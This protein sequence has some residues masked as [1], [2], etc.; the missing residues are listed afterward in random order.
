MDL[1]LLAVSPN[2]GSLPLWEAGE[3]ALQPSLGSL[4]LG[5]TSLA[6]SSLAQTR[7]ELLAA[8]TQHSSTPCPLSAVCLTTKKRVCVC[9]SHVDDL[10]LGLQSGGEGLDVGGLAFDSTLQLGQDR[11]QLR[12]GYLDQHTLTLSPPQPHASHPQPLN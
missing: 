11:L 5:S 12:H 4:L 7:M 8:G 10:V 2:A 3:G 6:V 1:F 9:P